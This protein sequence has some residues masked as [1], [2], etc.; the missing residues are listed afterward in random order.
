[1]FITKVH[2][3]HKR[4]RHLKALCSN[5][6]DPSTVLY[7]QSYPCR[8]QNNAQCCPLY[9]LSEDVN[10]CGSKMKWSFP[11]EI[12]P[13]C[14][15]RQV[16]TDGMYVHLLSVCTS[17]FS[18]PVFFRSKVRSDSYHLMFD[19][20]TNILCFEGFVREEMGITLFPP[21]L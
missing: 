1:M 10:D 19:S 18:F 2:H 20:K 16:I 15:E 9:L 7:H 4:K 11:E 8:V 17:H 21:S 14:S 6:L 3:I 12:I 5:S 13:F